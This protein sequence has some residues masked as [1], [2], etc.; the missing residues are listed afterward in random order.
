MRNTTRARRSGALLA[1]ALWMLPASAHAAP[2]DPATAEALF[3]DGRA[4]SEAGDFV[5]ACPLYAESLRLDYALGT[6]F[7]LASC[8]EHVGELV[9]AWEHYAEL[10]ERLPPDDERH[11]VARERAAYLD[12]VVPRLTIVVSAGAP[13]DTRVR[14]DATELGGPSLGVALPIDAGE[15][16][17]AVDAPGRAARQWVV[18][19]ALGERRVVVVV[20]G[21]P[22]A[23]MAPRAPEVATHGG[24]TAEWILG[25][26]GVASLAVGTYFGGRALAKRSQSDALCS[27]D[28]CRDPA[29]PQAY[30]DAKSFSRVADVT[31]GLGLV[32]VAAASYLLLSSSSREHAPP[33]APAVSFRVGPFGVG[34]TW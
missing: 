9:R 25:G 30:D 22:V 23:P 1:G 18:H 31:L 14:R 4:R 32:A 3:R 29:G 27:G 13:P 10:V 28:V 26:A 12:R 33:S 16:T 7:N 8:E 19:V 2:G 34:G 5:R 11:E 6:L 20:P 17:I 15:H 21:D 24:H